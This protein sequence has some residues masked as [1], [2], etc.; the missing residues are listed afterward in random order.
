MHDGELVETM[1]T[2][3]SMYPCC[4]RK[5][6]WM[7]RLACWSVSVVGLVGVPSARRTA[8]A[9]KMPYSLFTWMV[10]VIALPEDGRSGVTWYSYTGITSCSMHSPAVPVSRSKMD[11]P[12]SAD[13]GRMSAS[14]IWAQP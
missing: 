10:E 2:V 12:I 5:K 9:V 6:N 14:C 7:P 13:D 8:V 4:G 3:A 1:T 11:M